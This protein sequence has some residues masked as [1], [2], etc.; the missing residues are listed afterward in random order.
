[1]FSEQI[2]HLREPHFPESVAAVGDEE[3]AFA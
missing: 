2:G 3:D 1:M